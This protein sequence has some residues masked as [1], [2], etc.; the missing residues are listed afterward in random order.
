ME[1]KEVPKSREK[2]VQIPKFGHAAVC[3]PAN[4]FY[5]GKILFFVQLQNAPFIGHNFLI[6]VLFRN[7]FCFAVQMIIKALGFAYIL[8]MRYSLLRFL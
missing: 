4:I 2:Y 6:D 1:K 8:C 7:L 3:L 5:S